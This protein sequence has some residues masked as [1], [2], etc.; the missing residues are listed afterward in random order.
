MSIED[1]EELEDKRVC[2]NCVGEDYLCD[3]IEERGVNYQCSY[4]NDT[5]ATIFLEEL[6]DHV[7][8]AFEEHY[9]RTATEPDPLE[10]MMIK[11][12]D[13]NWEPAGEPTLDAISNAI[14][15]DEAVAQDVQKI[16]EEKHHDFEGAII[17]EEGEFDSEVH[18]EK[19][20]P[21]DGRW[22]AKWNSF[23]RTIKA[24]ARFFNRVGAEQLSELFDNIDGMRTNQGKPLI[25]D[26]G[27]NT[28]LH[29]LYRARVFQDD[30]QLKA[31]M[32]R[33]DKEL[34]SPPSRFASSGRMNADGI[35]VFYGATSINTA[36]TEVRPPVGS[37]VATARF[38]IIRQI[39]LL[40]LTLLQ[41]VHETGSIFDTDYADRLG[42]MMFL[43]KL[44]DRICRAV[45]PND[46][47]T[48][49]LPTQAIADYLATAG[50]VPLDGIL[51]PSAQNTRDGLNVVLFHKAAKCKEIDVPKGTE[52]YVSKYTKDEDGFQRSY[53]VTE[54]I[55][56]EK[57]PSK[58]NASLD[59]SD[60]LNLPP[61]SNFNELY[62]DGREETL[63][64][65]LESMKVHVVK[66]VKIDASEYKVSRHRRTKE[67]SS[68]EAKN[69]DMKKGRDVQLE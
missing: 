22:Q 19:I 69:V 64:I 39:R 8:S 58:D 18:Y 36:L 40:D 7:E 61:L 10:Q 24:E 12:C 1:S 62:S 49:Y 9:S 17:G 37:Q 32:K 35:S 21:G 45:M 51:F 41:E 60:I 31:A 11:E 14:E 28:D 27:P 20:M 34:S 25:I 56:P 38:E 6:A 26:A 59:F 23:E 48:E 52:F 53:S 5:G 50:K 46:E 2:C 3:L 47:K 15:V 16:L 13:S 29:H 43:Q 54:A 4:C 55:P 63:S 44:T 33:P 42:R 68:F 57:E 30:E 66:A 67:V 65:D